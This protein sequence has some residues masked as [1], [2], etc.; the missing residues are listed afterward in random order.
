MN[1]SEFATELILSSRSL[2]GG[3]GAH[4]PS[5]ADMRRAISSS[6]YAVFHCLAYHC[7]EAVIGEEGRQAR[8]AWRQTYRSLDHGRARQACNVQDGK[9]RAIL[10]RFPLGI[11]NFAH[12]FHSLQRKR[13][14][15]D[16]DPNF[17]TTLSEAIIWIDAAESAISDFEATDPSDRRA[18]VALVLF[19][20]RD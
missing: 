12:H 11:Q 5:Q 14:A 20:L 3:D 18:F 1:V 16:Y 13:H 6:Y 9:Y 2:V 19:P 15:A 8:R 17:E 10:E 7:A 4:A